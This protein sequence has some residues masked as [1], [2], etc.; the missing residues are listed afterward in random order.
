MVSTWDPDRF[1]HPRFARVADLVA[2][3]AREREWPSVATLDTVF[4]P[5]LAT[6]G[7]RLVEAAKTR[8]ARTPD[9]AIDAASLYE[10]RIVER[11]EVPTRPRSAHDLMN[12]L[13]WAAFPRTKLALTRVLATIQRDRAAGRATLANARTREHD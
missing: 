12:A 11:G 7:V 8:P 3:L 10:V 5:E 13:V 6:A 4:G 1:T 2:R 9:G